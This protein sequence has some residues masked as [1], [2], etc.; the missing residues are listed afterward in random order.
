MSKKFNAYDYFGQICN[1]HKI[2]R[3]GAYKF[4]RVSGLTYME[5]VL[6]NMRKERAFF[7]V[8]DTNDGQTYRVGGGWMDRRVY[9][10]YI[11]KRYK[12]N[13]MQEQHQALAECRKVYD[14]L[15]SRIIRDRSVLSQQGAVVDVSRFPYY[16]LEGYAIAGCTG[17]YTL[18]TIDEPKSLCYNVHEWQ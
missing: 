10:V 5:E 13:D 8:D 9:I 2:T 11:L 18:I 4:T 14:A 15:I 12:Q 1:E 3:N 17:L 6:A 7:A 16:E